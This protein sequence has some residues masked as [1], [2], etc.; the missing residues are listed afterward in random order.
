MRPPRRY[1]PLPQIEG[2]D[3]TIIAA[4]RRSEIGRDLR[5]R[6][7]FSHASRRRMI[8]WAREIYR[9]LREAVNEFLTDNCLHLAAS[10]SYYVLFC[11]FPLTLAAVSILGLLFGEKGVQEK[12][13]T[14]LSTFLPPVKEDF[15]KNAIEQVSQNWAATSAIAI[16]GLLWGGSAVFSALRKALNAAWGVKTPRPFHIERLMEL[17]MMAGVALLLTISFGLTTAVSVVENLSDEAMGSFFSRAIFW[18]AV[19][20]LLTGGLTFGTFL[21]LYKYVPNTKVRWADIWGGALLGAIA[22]EGAKYIYIWYVSGHSDYEHIYGGISTVV[23]LLVWVYMSSVILLFFAKL[24]SVYSRHMILS[25]TA[26]PW[27]GKKRRISNRI[28]LGEPMP[29]GGD[30]NPDFGAEQRER[31]SRTE[32]P[33]STDDGQTLEDEA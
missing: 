32:F 33:V 31:Y 21:M 23:A 27:W 14:A 30:V 26:Y 13:I 6:L 12:V 29:L 24:T 25:P 18:D 11:L 16:G 17:G 15:I 4:L 10:I 1:G 9:F 3:D 20:M 2:M 7:D 8:G 28:R 19:R 5:N 22:F